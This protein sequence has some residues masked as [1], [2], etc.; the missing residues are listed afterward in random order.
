[1]IALFLCDQGNRVLVALFVHLFAM[2]VI[3][4]LVSYLAVRI[5][6]AHVRIAVM[7]IDQFKLL[8]DRYLLSVGNELRGKGNVLKGR[9]YRFL[10][11]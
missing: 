1:M 10:Y 3:H 6:A 8:H 2:E 9:I 11:S 7:T 4:T 5:V